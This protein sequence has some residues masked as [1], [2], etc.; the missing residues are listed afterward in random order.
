M[1]SVKVDW[2]FA[3]RTEMINKGREHQSLSL[4]IYY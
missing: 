2:Q 1:L 4:K 3:D